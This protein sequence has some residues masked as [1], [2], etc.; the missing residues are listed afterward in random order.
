MAI[1][2]VGA[3]IGALT[4]VAGT[5]LTF[6]GQRQAAKDSQ[7]MRKQQNYFSKKAEAAREQQALLEAQRT[8]RQAYREGQQA[9]AMSLA[10]TVNQGASGSSGQAGA[11][12]SATSG[13]LGRVQTAGAA[14]GL[15]GQVF[16]A[17]RDYADAT[18]RGENAIAKSQQ[19]ANLGTAI[20][21]FGQMFSQNAQTIQRVG[22]YAAA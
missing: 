3:A 22:T 9:R 16:Q 13:A 18:Y 5:V 10:N 12:A 19:F 11:L 14:A 6:I 2:G 7:T 8:K 17:N 1:A 15:A 20:S 21:G 4:S